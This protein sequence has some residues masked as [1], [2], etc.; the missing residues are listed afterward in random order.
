MADSISAHC[1]TIILSNAYI[2]LE[3]IIERWKDI[4]FNKG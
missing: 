4:F 3:A 2:F 1:N